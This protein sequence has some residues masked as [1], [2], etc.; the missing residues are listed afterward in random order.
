[1]TPELDTMRSWGIG[2]YNKLGQYLTEQLFKDAATFSNVTYPS[3]SESIANESA[4]GCGD[5]GT[6]TWAE[7]DEES[8]PPYNS[9]GVRYIPIG[10]IGGKIPIS[11]KTTWA[12]NGSGPA[13]SINHTHVIA[14]NYPY[15]SLL[16]SGGGATFPELYESCCISEFANTSNRNQT[17]GESANNSILMTQELR[18]GDDLIFSGEST[19]SYNMTYA[20]RYRDWETDRK[21]TRLNSSHPA[22]SRMPSSA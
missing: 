7:N 10:L 5:C 17:W 21:S 15:N 19:M 1:M 11:M 3:T 16:E 20:F 4:C 6:G 22:K 2:Y 14:G 12:Q 9:S 13:K 8:V 18:V